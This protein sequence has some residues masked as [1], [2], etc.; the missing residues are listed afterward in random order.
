MD[1]DTDYLS[2]W[3]GEMKGEL[4]SE[5]IRL[6]YD[7]FQVNQF[8]S[9]LKLKLILKEQ[10]QLMFSG[11]N[12]LSLGIM[13]VLYTIQAGRTKRWIAFGWREKDPAEL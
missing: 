7:T 1:N 5:S 13:A 3:L 12:K 2:R 8:N 9:R 10:L 6:V 4:D 11:T